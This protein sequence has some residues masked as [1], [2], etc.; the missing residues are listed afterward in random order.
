MTS[1]SF[2]TVTNLLTIAKFYSL[3]KNQDHI[4]RMVQ[5][6][7]RPEFQPKSDNQKKVLDYYVRLNKKIL[8]CFFG[9]CFTTCMLWVV[10]P[11]TVPVPEDGSKGL[12][13]DA[14]SPISTDTTLNYVVVFSYQFVATVFGGFSNFLVD[15]LMSGFV[16]VLCA[17]LEL[18][19]D[20][21]RNLKPFAEKELSDYIVEDS[22]STAVETLMNKKLIECVVHHR[23]I[24]QFKNES[25]A[26]FT[27]VIFGQFVLSIL[28]NCTTLFQMSVVDSIG[29]RLCSLM[30]YQYCMLTELLLF[31]YSG[32]EL[33]VQSSQLLSSA[34]HCDWMNTSTKFRKNL[35]YFM[36]RSQI[37]MK[38]YVG[39]FFTMSIVSFFKILKSSWSYYAL[40]VQVNG[41]NRN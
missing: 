22:W 10:Y 5:D 12:M 18:L 25:E 21:L 15:C 3:F 6:I 4:M 20:T 11:F 24:I 8:F 35:I 41:E 34:Y 36:T 28:I 9:A 38:T 39:N 7:N 19:N 40:L 23:Y 32:N 31:C 27:Y 26:L 29:L 37:V 2:L 13:I 33:I 17:Q 30:F 1:A 14:W 16:I